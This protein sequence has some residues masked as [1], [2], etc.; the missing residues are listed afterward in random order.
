MPPSHIDQKLE[1]SKLWSRKTPF[2][3]FLRWVGIYI[4]KYFKGA[5]NGESN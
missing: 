2:V 4:T 5:V 1:V 3:F